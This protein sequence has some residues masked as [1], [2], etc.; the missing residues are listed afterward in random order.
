MRRGGAA[1]VLARAGGRLR[2]LKAGLLAAG[3]RGCRPRHT[4]PC[5]QRAA[6]APVALA[7]PVEPRPFASG[8]MHKPQRAT[9]TTPA[10]AAACPPSPLPPPVDAAAAPPL[11]RTHARP[12]ARRR[13]KPRAFI[14]GRRR[15]EMRGGAPAV[16]RAHAAAAQPAHRSAPPVCAGQAGRTFCW[17]PH[18]PPPARRSAA[19]ASLSNG[20]RLRGGRRGGYLQRAGPRFSGARGTRVVGGGLSKIG[21]GRVRPAGATAVGAPGQRQQWG[22]GWAG[23]RAAAAAACWRVSGSGGGAAGGQEGLCMV[24]GDRC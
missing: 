10:R 15:S 16:T 20:R 17:R 8:R 19:T 5:T 9:A 21:A 11:T 13:P 4:L 12:P 14:H 7:A 1:P 18:L 2:A 23:G 22:Q 6:H 3:L 24:R